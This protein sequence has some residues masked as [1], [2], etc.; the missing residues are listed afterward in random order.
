MLIIVILLIGA[1]VAIILVSMAHRDDRVDA[2]HAAAEVL[3]VLMPWSSRRRVSGQHPG[4]D[5]QDQ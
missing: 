1:V 4:I 3:R 2:I 5:P